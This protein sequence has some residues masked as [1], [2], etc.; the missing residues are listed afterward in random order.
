MGVDP[1]DRLLSHYPVHRL[2]GESIRD[3]ILALQRPDLAEKLDAFRPNILVS[4]IGMPHQDGYALIRRVRAKSF[5]GCRRVTARAGPAC[6][7]LG[8]NEAL[9]R[10][11]RSDRGYGAVRRRVYSD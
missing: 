11:P 3:A 4:D 6:R 9:L 5:I 1:Q 7:T 2:E 8:K 10:Q